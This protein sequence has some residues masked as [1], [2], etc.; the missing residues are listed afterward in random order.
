MCGCDRS[1][2]A[3]AFG[4]GNTYAKLPIDKMVVAV[5][6]LSSVPAFPRTTFTSSIM[7]SLRT[8]VIAATMLPFAS[9]FIDSV[10]PYSGTYT[11]TVDSTFPVT[12]IAGHAPGATYQDLIVY[13]GLATPDEMTAS[14]NK[15]MG[16]PVPGATIDLVA[17]KADGLGE[18]RTFQVPLHA[19][20]FKGSA[21]SDYY[22]VAVVL[23]ANLNENTPA[24]IPELRTF[25][26]PFTG[27]APRSS[28]DSASVSSASSAS[29]ASANSTPLS[30][31]SSA[32]SSQA[33]AWLPFP[34]RIA[35]VMFY[36]FVI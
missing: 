16:T 12:F 27:S 32:S 2:A 18:D 15:S 25:R 35:L 5:S 30:S 10:G 33:P 20:A 36:F 17:E 13:F 19:D 9:A 7:F 3:A 23:T 6:P 1:A 14:K 29:L 28:A 31:P 26:I 34:W 21:E 22:L 8:L 4:K 11:A 24:N